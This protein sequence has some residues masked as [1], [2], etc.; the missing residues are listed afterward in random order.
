MIKFAEGYKHLA[1]LNDG[2]I[3]GRRKASPV[4]V[5]KLR[6]Y[7]WKTYNLDIGNFS[8]IVTIAFSDNPKYRRVYDYPSVVLD[9][10]G[11]EFGKT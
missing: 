6:D 7:W 4:D 11:E 8:Y 10:T 9:L 3:V 5:Q 1:P 2:R